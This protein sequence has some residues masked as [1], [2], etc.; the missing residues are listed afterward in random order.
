[1]FRPLCDYVHRLMWTMSSLTT[2]FDKSRHQDELIKTEV[3][4]NR[5]QEFPLSTILLCSL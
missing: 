3:K 1:M 2:S 4:S 5:R